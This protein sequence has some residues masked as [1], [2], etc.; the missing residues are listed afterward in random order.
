MNADFLR[1][2]GIIAIAVGVGVLVGAAGLFLYQQLYAEKRRMVLRRELA[3]LDLKVAEIRNELDVQCR[4]G[5]GRRSVLRKA[6]KKSL[7]T[8]ETEDKAD[9]DLHWTVDT[10]D[11]DDD[12]FFDCSDEN[13]V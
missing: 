7:S 1:Y 11:D 13:N 4:K 8:A 3:Q 5:R 2:R 10:D 12:E 9:R 6:N